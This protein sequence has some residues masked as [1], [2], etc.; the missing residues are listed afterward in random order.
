M[1]RI[2]SAMLLGAALLTGCRSAST[3]TP[4]TAPTLQQQYLKA[5]QTMDDFSADVKQAQQIEIS[6]YKASLPGLD[7]PTHVA[8]QKGFLQTATYGKEIDA[9]IAGQASAATIQARVAVALQS[10]QSITLATGQLDASA[11][12]NLKAAIQ[13]LTLILNTV[14]AA[15]PIQTGELHGPR[16]YRNAGS[17]GLVARYDYLPAVQAS[18]RVRWF[19][20]KE[21]AGVSV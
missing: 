15:F 21:L 16:T 7:K 10:I 6:L 20:G 13:A 9:L 18:A 14:S 3:G 1:T 2:I 4:P 19:T 17:T 12:A 5:A 11:T 8:V